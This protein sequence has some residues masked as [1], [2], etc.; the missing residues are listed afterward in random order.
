M[1][2]FLLEFEADLRSRV[3][4]VLW[5]VCALSLASAGPFGSYD[6]FSFAQRLLLWVPLT[7]TAILCVTL[8]R[9]FVYGVL[10]MRDFPRGSIVIA[11]LA[12]VLICPPMHAL[13]RTLFGASVAERPSWAELIMLVGSITLGVCSLRHSLRLP[14]VEEAVTVPPPPPEVMPRLVARLEP[15]VQGRLQAISVRDHYVDVQTSLGEGSLLMRFSDAIAEVTPVDGTQVHRSHWVAW[16]A[17]AAV[18]KAEGKLFVRLPSGNR[19]PVSRNH[20]EK[21]EARGLI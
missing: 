2:A 18:E 11:V 10:K 9:A 19:L 1:S 6:R 5:L 16:E 12:C 7:A 20:R 21:L 14:V 3:P 13:A 15:A 17:I 8:L 4:L